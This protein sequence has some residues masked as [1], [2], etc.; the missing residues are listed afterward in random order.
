MALTP[1]YVRAC[2]VEIGDDTG[3]AGVMLPDGR[4][5]IWENAGR[6]TSYRDQAALLAEHPGATLHMY[7][8]ADEV[9]N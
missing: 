4:M 2:Y 8:E 5:L 9:L 1:I 6:I 3:Y 7:P